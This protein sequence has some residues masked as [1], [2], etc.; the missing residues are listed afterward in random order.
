MEGP[1]LEELTVWQDRN[2]DA[3]CQPDELTSLA[4]HGIIKL[5]TRHS[6]FVSRYVTADG[7]THAMWDWWPAT[8]EVRKLRRAH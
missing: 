7:Q 5:S 3:V 1:E 2:S 6:N 4:E 8:L